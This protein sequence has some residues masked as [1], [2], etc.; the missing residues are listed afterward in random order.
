[1]TSLMISGP[2]EAACSSCPC[3]Q[4]AHASPSVTTSRRTFESTNVIP[5]RR[6]GEP[7]VRRSSCPDQLTRAPQQT[8]SA[9]EVRQLFRSPRHHRRGGENPPDC[10]VGSPNSRGLVLGLS[11]DPCG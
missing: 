10:R 4:S 11:L 7:S 3:D 2:T 9:A 1:M 8:C 6:E 5:V